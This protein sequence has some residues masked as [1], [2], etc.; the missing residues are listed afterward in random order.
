MHALTNHAFEHKKKS[1]FSAILTLD[2]LLVA[3][4]KTQF[5]LAVYHHLTTRQTVVLGNMKQHVASS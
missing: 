3:K 5:S 2:T 4:N 1:K